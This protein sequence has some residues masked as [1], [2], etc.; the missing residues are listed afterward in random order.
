M[1]SGKPRILDVVEVLDSESTRELELVGA[2]GI[3]IGLTED[4]DTR[5]HWFAVQVGDLPA[6]MLARKDLR[7]TGRSVTRESIYS[8]D[9]LRVSR[10]GEPLYDKGP[11]S[12]PTDSGSDGS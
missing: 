3:V 7:L 8:G 6:V 10:E 4:D 2:E 12:H 11:S 5:E 9:R 1:T